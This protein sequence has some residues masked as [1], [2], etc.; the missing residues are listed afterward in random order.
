MI[1]ADKEAEEFMNPDLN[2][3]VESDSQL[4]T[5]LVDYVGRKYQGEVA[6]ARVETGQEIEWDGDVTVDMIVETFSAEFPEFLMAIAEENFIRGYKQG[7]SDMDTGWGLLD[8][9][10]P[11]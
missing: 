8:A 6:R 9:R 4:K 2:K 7:I 3:A 11:E 1:I 5:W 10:Q